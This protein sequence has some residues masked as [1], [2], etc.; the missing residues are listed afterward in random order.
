[1]AR[2]PDA[3]DIESHMAALRKRLRKDPTRKW[4]PRY[5]F[6]SADVA[7]AA[8]ILNSGSLLSRARA[9]EERQLQTDSAS[10]GIISGLSKAETEL[11][12]LY[13]RPKAPTQFAN[14]GSRPAGKYPYG[15]GMAVPVY[16]MFSA[17]EVLTEEGVRFSRG[18]LRDTSDTG[19]DADF[20]RSIPFR[21]V[22]HDG[23]MP[24]GRMDAIKD[25]RHAEILVPDLLELD[26]LNFVVCRSVAEK[27]TLLALLDSAVR[28]RWQEMITL[29]G[30]QSMYF[31]RWNYV[32]SVDYDSGHALF[33]FHRAVDIGE[34][35]PFALKI[36]L[37]G[38]DGW[39]GRY[40]RTDYESP[41][42]LRIRF[43]QPCTKYAI[44]M[45]LD[46]EL[47]YQGN[48]AE[49]SGPALY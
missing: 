21:D 43:R 38:D 8:S 20:L 9:L 36:R 27:Q 6:H 34:R 39:V 41:R 1:M 7:N 24:A 33:N 49:S 31:K 5:V 42:S 10:P 26:K 12:R 13:F 37:Y 2:K 40:D 32:E 23:P 44:K 48:Y 15:G 45:N 18:R 29:P 17:S 14:E 16:L 19:D 22:Y 47:V 30:A 11:V 46:G 28:E 3:T 4:W 25:A 35:A